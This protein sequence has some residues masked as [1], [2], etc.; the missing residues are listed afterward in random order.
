MADGGPAP[1][2]VQGYSPLLLAPVPFYEFFTNAFCG[3]STLI[4]A[5]GCAR[6][7]GVYGFFLTNGVLY[8]L[9]PTCVFSVFRCCYH[10]HT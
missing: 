4:Q 8:S 2:P 9:L 3:P 10:G 6:L 7:L 5:V 1:F